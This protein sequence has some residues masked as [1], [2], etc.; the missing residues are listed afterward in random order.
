MSNTPLV[1][2]VS[3]GCVLPSDF[4]GRSG[5]GRNDEGC[6]TDH[7]E[8]VYLLR[9]V[10]DVRSEAADKPA[11]ARWSGR[12]D[13]FPGNVVALRKVVSSFST[14]TST[15]VLYQSTCLLDLSM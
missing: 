11:H 9:R 2:G 4:N 10:G 14:S 7:G 3:G 1:V 8:A 5:V 15:H 13:L 6:K 12:C